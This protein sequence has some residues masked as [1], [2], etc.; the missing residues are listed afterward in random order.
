MP[1]MVALKKWYRRFSPC[2]SLDIFRQIMKGKPIVSRS[3]INNLQIEDYGLKSAIIDWFSNNPASWNI[4]WQD[5]QCQSV[6]W[7]KKQVWMWLDWTSLILMRILLRWRGRKF[8]VESQGAFCDPRVLEC[9]L[10]NF[11]HLRRLPVHWTMMATKIS[12][13]RLD[14]ADRGI[15]GPACVGH[16]CPTPRLPCSHWKLRPVILL[17]TFFAEWKLREAIEDF[18]EQPGNLG[19]L[20]AK[21]LKHGWSW[22]P[23]I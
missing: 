21:V 8:P 9:W 17:P 11:Q 15:S 16:Y 12:G 19:N 20:G 3:I 14:Y 13:F 2:R 6:C 10:M 18:V 7:K 22:Y 1:L 4:S 23:G 5:W